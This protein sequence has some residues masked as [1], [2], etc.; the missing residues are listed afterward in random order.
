M[1]PVSLSCGTAAARALHWTAALA[2]FALAAGAC[3]ADTAPVATAV[4]QTRVGPLTLDHGLPTLDTRQKL[5]DELDFQRA[6]QG[7]L[8]A[9]PAINNALFLRAMQVAGVPNLGAMV[10]D[11]RMHPGQETLTPNESVVYLYDSINLKEVGPV[12]YTTPESPINGGFFDMW[13]RPVHDFGTVGP[14]RGKGDRILLVPPGFEGA[15][16]EGYQVVRPR[17]HQ[18]FTITRLTVKDGMTEEQATTLLRQI[19][20]YRLADAVHAPPKTFVLMGDPAHGGKEFRMNR[21]TGLEYWRMVHALIDGETVED[22]DR[23]TLGMLASIGI[24]RGKPFAPDS[25]MQQLL[26]EAETVGKLMMV[27]EAF[28][29]RYAPDGVTRELYPET[30]WEN[31]QLLPSMSQEGPNSTYVMPRLIGFYQANGAQFAWDPRDYPPGFGQKYAAAYKDKEGEW[32]KGGH[33]YRLRVPA[34]VPVA[35][36]WALTV[37]DVDTRALVEAAQHN[38]E[39]NPN[40][41]KLKVNDDGSIDLYFG[42]QAPPGYESN[43]IQTVPG[44][45]WF[46]YFRWYGPTQPYYDKSWRLPDIERVDIR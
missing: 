41:R 37:Y 44:R 22:R 1:Q 31:I 38:A 15:I 20:T 17:T 25:R 39:I 4:T 46:T 3:V 30:Q 32:L 23:I 36:F 7:V 16:P 35:D 19:R 10:Y 27:N 26:V 6:V 33:S 2:G 14:N 34:N 11:R 43:W 13:M 28:S 29:P 21:P 9:E 8:W 18:L 42:L 5:Y 12:V 24:E 45:G 40:V